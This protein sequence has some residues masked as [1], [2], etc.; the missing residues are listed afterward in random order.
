[1]SRY[2]SVQSQR[3]QQRIILVEHL[4]LKDDVSDLCFSFNSH[5]L[6]I[7][8]W[9]GMVNVLEFNDDY[10]ESK[11]KTSWSPPSSS[12]SF[13]VGTSTGFGAKTSIGSGGGTKIACLRC[14]F[15]P[16][17]DVLYF[18]TSAGEIYSWD[19]S[20]VKPETIHTEKPDDPRKGPI[21]CLKWNDTVNCLVALGLTTSMSNALGLG[22]SMITLAS[23]SSRI[24]LD[25]KPIAM[26]VSGKFAVVVGT[27][28]SNVLYCYDL[29]K[30]TPQSVQKVG[31]GIGSSL[32]KQFTSV[33]CG[34]V[35]S[36]T[37][38]QPIVIVSNVFGQADYIESNDNHST[39]N[40]HLSL[41]SKTAMSSNSIIIVPGHKCAVSAGSDGNITF[42]NLETK[43]TKTYQVSQMPL[44]RIAANP[45][46]TILAI[47]CGYDW[48]FGYE[49]AGREKPKIQLF[50]RQFNQVDYR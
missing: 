5:Y 7:T 38:T 10:S 43:K 35:I 17:D 28:G 18:S 16:S 26:D 20:A 47:S 44:T 25:Y 42:A 12:T 50:I 45:Q 36:S 24:D 27:N 33:A 11:L 9:D 41:N 6:A 32:T 4:E 40:L 2:T 8:S 14:V 19:L 34:P 23:E 22:G 39:I 30:P 48:S 49:M 15:R 46:G 21:V 31:L 37:A 29:S 1:M 13:G 3:P